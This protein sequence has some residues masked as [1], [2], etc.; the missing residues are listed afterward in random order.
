MNRNQFEERNKRFNIPQHELDRMYRVLREQMMM[1]E[2]MLEAQRMGS[3]QVSSGGSGIAVAPAGLVISS[4]DFTNGVPINQDTS[5][6]GTNGVD[7]FTNTA[8]QGNFYE[9]YYGSGLTADAVD[10][11]TAAYVE[12]GL[13]PTNSVGYVW[14]ATWGS[15]SSITTGLVKF[16]FYAPSGYFDLQTIDPADPDWELPGVNNGTTLAGT[17]L[18]PLTINIYTPLV[19]KGGW[20]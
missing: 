2:L 5:A 4:S 3:S 15:G 12:A 17:F 16:G 8:S 6:L 11:I 1:E 19:N 18:F 10:R 20:C 7:G 14:T 13:D 9:G